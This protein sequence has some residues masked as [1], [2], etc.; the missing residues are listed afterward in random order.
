MSEYRRCPSI[1]SV[2]VHKLALL[3][4]DEKLDDMRSFSNSIFSTHNT[5]RAAGSEFVKELLCPG[6]SP[7]F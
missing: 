4:F 2:R 1:V 6:N 3:P 5:E 7:R